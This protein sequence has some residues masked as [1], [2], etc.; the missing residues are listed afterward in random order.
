MR[1]LM[2]HEAGHD[3]DRL[4]FPSIQGCHAIALLTQ[5]ALFGF[6]NAGGS[7]NDKFDERARLF[8]GYVRRLSGRK[9]RGVHLY[10]STFVGNNQRGYGGTN[11][12]ETW[13]LELAKFAAA[14]G[15][16]GPISGCDLAQTITAP[17]ASAYVEYRKVG[18]ACYVFAK[19]W[20][21]AG[22]LRVPYVATPDLEK[23]VGTQ[24]NQIMTTGVDASGLTKIDPVVIK[25]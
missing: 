4:G 7:G 25:A 19:Q 24:A 3:T 23:I 18:Q 14:L 16:R 17:G 6:H 2:E 8:A 22:I 11:V 20:T 5:D 15:F 12:A 21:S 13:K 9:I 10:G 1:Y